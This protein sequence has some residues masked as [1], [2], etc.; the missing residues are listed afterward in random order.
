MNSK[1]DLWD[2]KLVD[3]KELQKK[4]DFYSSNG[5]ESVGF[6]GGDIS[7]HPKI[8]EIISYSKKV[9][10]K[11]ISIISNGMRFSNA[12]LARSVVDAGLT[13][14]NI[15]I[16]SHLHDIEN[17]LTCVPGGL[18]KKLSAIDNFN[19]LHNSGLLRALISINIVL[20]RHNLATIVETVL[21]F[22]SKK[23]I[24]DI[25]INFVWLDEMIKENWDD[26]KIS[27]SEFLPY[28]KS[29][30]YISLKYKFRLTFDT[31][32][33]CIFYKIDP[34]NYKYLINTFLGEN[35]DHITEVDWS[36]NNTVFDWQEKKK[37]LL[38]T[39]F[40]GCSK[41]L[42][43]NKCQGVWKE[44]S[45]IYG[46]G[47]F[48]PITQESNKFVVEI[49][50][51]KSEV[52]DKNAVIKK[53][54][55]GNIVRVYKNNKYILLYVYTSEKDATS[56]H[57]EK[58]LIKIILDLK[59]DF[60]V[61][62]ILFGK[63]IDLAWIIKT[64]CLYDF[65]YDGDNIMGTIKYE[66]SDNKGINRLGVNGNFNAIIE[67][68]I[69]NKNYID[70]ILQGD[71]KLYIKIHKD[72]IEKYNNIVH[73]SFGYQPQIGI[74]QYTFIF[75]KESNINGIN[76]RFIEK[77][78]NISISHETL[79]YFFIKIEGKEYFFMREEIKPLIMKSSIK[80]DTIDMYNRKLNL[81][82]KLKVG[83]CIVYIKGVI[84]AKYYN[85]FH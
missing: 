47:E 22:Y 63:E 11:D 38:K 39:Q 17:Y 78:I 58:F 13:R 84:C 18:K 48:T 65:V 7:I 66:F 19:E 23:K 25:R 14:I 43:I 9:G 41:C 54:V 20:N 83:D 49:D 12:D 42:Y 81:D 32:P 80:I 2:I 28:L 34:R 6:L 61:V 45:Q 3:L 4:L 40:S 51:N 68:D 30:V 5:Y 73:Y 46:G 8:I 10:F 35:L 71:D 79:T 62:G 53:K 75:N 27:Y 26:L 57:F 21:F 72:N 77:D 74:D 67:N 31:V 60:H 82:L 33:A 59:H 29:L 52:I 36:N 76:Y 69:I 56:R 55:F 15:S 1:P 85:D 64:T 24:K 50:S 70:N 44:Y 37:D 16:H